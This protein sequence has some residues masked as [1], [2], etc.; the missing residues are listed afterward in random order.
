MKRENSC[1]L[2]YLWTPNTIASQAQRVSEQCRNLSERTKQRAM[3]Q[4]GEMTDSYRKD[5]GDDAK[6]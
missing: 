3:A 6:K 4:K 1:E 5:A 2:G